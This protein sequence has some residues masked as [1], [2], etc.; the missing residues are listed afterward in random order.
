MLGTTIGDIAPPESQGETMQPVN[1]TE[2]QMVNETVQIDLNIE[3][4][5]VMCNF[6]LM[7][8][9]ESEDLLVGFPIGL[10]W[11]GHGGDRYIYPLEDFKAYLNS[12]Q[13][14]TREM[15]VNG[16]QWIVWNMSLETM[17]T[18]D[19][20]VSYWVQLSSYGNYGREMDYWFTYVLKTGASWGGLIEEANITI[21]LHGIEQNWI[22]ELTPNGSVF[23]NNIITWNFISL[24]PTENIYIEFR[25]LR[26]DCEER[27]TIPGFVFDENHAGIPDATAELHYWNS[28]DSTVGEIVDDVYGEPLVTTTASGADG[29]VGWYRLTNLSDDGDLGVPINMTVVARTLDVAGNE[30]TG[31]SDPIGFDARLGWIGSVVNVTVDR[32]LAPGDLDGDG[33]L[34]TS[35]ALAA[36]MIAASGVHQKGADV[37]GDSRVNSVDALMILQAASGR[38]EL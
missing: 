25:T 35:D 14:E 17:E 24:E 22:T 33:N 12:Q 34:T 8:P 29:V 38:T 4:A 20:D 31:I 2:V 13:V 9:G 37:N 21:D 19:V 26:P 11:G 5:T 27:Y 36:L 6:T 16:S 15:D 1:V 30:R 32:S 18:K 28:D 23:E 3:N 7:N 10:G